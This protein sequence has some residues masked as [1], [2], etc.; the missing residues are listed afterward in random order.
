MGLLKPAGP[1]PKKGP[2]KRITIRAQ[3]ETIAEKTGKRPSRLDGPPCPPE[4][5]YVWEWYCS[6]RPIGSLVEIK[7]WADLYGRTLKPHE[8]TLMRR[9]ASVEERVALS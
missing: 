1:R 6:A 4:L 2:D 5:G 7:A 9:L 3:L 8:I